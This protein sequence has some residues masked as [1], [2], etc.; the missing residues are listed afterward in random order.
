M[1]ALLEL[2]WVFVQI[3]AFAFGGGYAVLPL[4]QRFVVEERGWLNMKEMTDLV[5]IS[6]MT[7]GPIAIN[8]ATFV[9][10]KVAGIPGAIVATLGNVTPQFILMMTLAFF[11]FRDKKIG[12]LDKMLKGLKPGIVGLIAIA[13]ISMFRSSLFEGGVIAISS[14]SIVAAVA[15]VVGFVLKLWKRFDLIVLILLGAVMGVVGNL[16][17]VGFPT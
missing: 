6:Q 13:A 3:G 7:P 2:Y 12:F 16:L 4:I 9:G 15:F 5:S 11:I 8:S 10:T 17:L 14:L 1:M